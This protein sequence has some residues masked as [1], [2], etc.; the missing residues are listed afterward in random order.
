M[1]F[2]IIILS[3]TG[4]VLFGDGVIRALLGDV[5]KEN[6]KEY[7]VFVIF[8]PLILIMLLLLWLIN[9]IIGFTK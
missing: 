1:T 6:P 4:Y 5:D 7:V 9:L 2:F 8:W 3:L